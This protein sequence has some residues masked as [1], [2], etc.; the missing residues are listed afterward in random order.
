[1][2]LDQDLA[3]R[4]KIALSPLPLL[5]LLV[6][7]CFQLVISLALLLAFHIP[8]RLQ[9]QTVA[10]Y[11]PVRRCHV[12]LVAAKNPEEFLLDDLR[13]RSLPAR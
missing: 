7:H 9:R 1:M 4:E 10:L 3:A 5:F 11:H 8:A 12:A 2:N 13:R 6:L